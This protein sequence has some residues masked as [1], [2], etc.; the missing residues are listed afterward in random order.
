MDHSSLILAIIL[1]AGVLALALGGGYF[2]SRSDRFLLTWAVGLAVIVAGMTAF[3]IFIEAPLPDLGLPA[4]GLILAGLVIIEAAAFQYRFRKSPI[5]RAA[6]ASA[7]AFALVCPFFLA[8]ITGVGTS[9][10]NFLAF[11]LLTSAGHHYWRCRAEA[12]ILIA[13]QSVLYLAVGLSFLICAVVILVETPI[14]RVRTP[15]NWAENLNAVAGIVGLA[16][17]GA[18]SLCLNQLRLVGRLRRETLTDALTGL[19]NRRALF[20]RYGGSVLAPGTAVA[21]FD[22][23]NFKQVN[24]RHGHAAG[25]AVLVRFAGLLAGCSGPHLFAARTGG[26]EFVLVMED[27]ASDAGE[28]VSRLRDAFAAL[29]TQT[30]GGALRCTASAGIALATTANGEFEKILEEADKALYQAKGSGRNA[31]ATHFRVVA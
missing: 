6:L 11:V 8:G 29:P 18:I 16:G 30:A 23:D 17:I 20:V 9:L 22:L 25:D 12:P 1:V 27:A 26:E 13:I 14:A 5:R 21:V 31:V 3:A 15:D 4:F 10:V 19:S 7:A 2:M 24:D 28:T